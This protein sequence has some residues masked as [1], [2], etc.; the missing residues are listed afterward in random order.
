MT[1]NNLPRIKKAYL[2]ARESFMAVKI[3]IQ[4]KS[5][6]PKPVAKLPNVVADPD[7]EVHLAQAL[8]EIEDLFVVNLWASFERTLRDYFQAKGE[9][10]KT[11][12]PAGLGA[13]LYLHFENEVEYWKPEDMLEI[14]KKSLFAESP[15]NQRLAGHARQI[16]HYRNWVAHGRNPN[17]PPSAMVAPNAAYTTLNTLLGLLAP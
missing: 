17:K 10:L 4:D 8:Q 9:S 14:L 16:Y 5:R 12:L 7:P 6:Y 15:D 13:E 3:V 1:E 11:A 2:T